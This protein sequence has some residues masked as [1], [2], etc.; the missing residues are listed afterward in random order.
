[1]LKSDILYYSRQETLGGLDPWFESLLDN[2]IDKDIYPNVN[3]LQETGIKLEKELKDYSKQFNIDTV[4]I[5]LSGG[6]DSALTASLF[7]SAGWNVKPFLLPIRQNPQETQRAEQTAKA[8]ALDY[9]II[10]LTK[11]YEKLIKDVKTFDD[12]IIDDPIRSGNLRVRLRMMT[13]YNLASKYKGLVASTDNF[14]ELAAGFWTLHGD[15][16]DLAPIQS[17]CKSWEVPKLAEYYQVPEN[18]VMATPTDGLGISAGDED[19]FGFSYLE[20]DLILLTL[21]SGIQPYTLENIYNTLNVPGHLQLKVNTI[22]KRIRNSVYKRNNPCNILHPYQ[23]Q[24]FSGLSNL[25]R[26][27]IKNNIK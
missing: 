9:S 26:C 19:Q 11:T 4:I 27:L 21:C 23:K 18:T 12:G 25:D 15:V 3:T 6:V 8:L 22:L 5:G 16:G 2:L 14:S 17:L 13:L 1:M 7:K 10:D 24:R 20:L